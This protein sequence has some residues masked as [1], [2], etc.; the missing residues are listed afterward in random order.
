MDKG[1]DSAIEQFSRFLLSERNASRETV[2]AYLREV[3]ELRQFLSETGKGF[4]PHDGS[5]SWASVSV[6][7]M[8][9]FLAA[10][11]PGKKG[12]TMARKIAA[13]RTFFSFLVTVGKIPGNPAAGV[14]APRRTLRLPEFLPVDEMMD[15]LRSLP[16]EGE[17]GKRDAAILELLYSSGLR[18]GELVSLRRMDV[19]LPE[20]TVRVRGKGRKVRVVPAG[21]KALEALSS[22]LAERRVTGK[23][24][25]ADDWEG[26]LFRNLRGGALSARSVARILD[27]ALE[28]AGI[29]RHLSP[30][31]VRHSFATHLLESGADLRAIQEM[32]GHASLS[33][34]QRYAR[35]NVSH[36]VRAYEQ[37][38]PRAT[39]SAQRRK[40]V[41]SGRRDE[42]S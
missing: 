38:H 34:T 2:R 27:R 31:G 6:A 35:V 19:S 32:L 28:R 42:R 8:R 25:E 15:L 23:R 10:R 33:T 24:G 37:A 22:Y 16:A 14:T 21:E 29:G 41:P 5:L 30:H 17:A 4:S 13:L 36:L 11:Y 7:D 20:G 9:R 18:V 3:S 1:L 39:G 26:A 40:P 12:S